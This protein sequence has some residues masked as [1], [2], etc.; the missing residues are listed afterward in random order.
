[1]DHARNH[2]YAKRGGGAD[3]IP[4]EEAFLGTRARGIEV[5]ALDDALVSLSKVDPRK[6][7]VVELRYFGGLTVEETAALLQIS[8]ETAMRDW[9]LA[10]SW[11][12]RELTRTVSKRK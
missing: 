7:R 12:L 9:K 3:H 2:K 8:P 1:M 11:L 6:A 5:L 4:L 10:K